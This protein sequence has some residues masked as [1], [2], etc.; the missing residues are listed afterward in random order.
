MGAKKMISLLLAL[1]LFGGTVGMLSACTP[2]AGEEVP[3]E[4]YGGLVV[5]PAEA[6]DGETPPITF[7]VQPLERKELAAY[8]VASAAIQGK[9][10]TANVTPRDAEDELDWSVAWASRV[11]EEW[12]SKTVTDYITVE[13]DPDDSHV[14]TVYCMQPFA[15]PIEVTAMIHNRPK[16]SA[17]CTAHFQQRYLNMTATISY[18]SRNRLE[19]GF[20]WEL[21]SEQNVSLAFPGYTKTFD[22]FKQYYGTGQQTG[23]FTVKITV[24]YKDEPYTIR[25]YVGEGDYYATV[26]VTSTSDYQAA[27]TASGGALTSGAMYRTI[28]TGSDWNDNAITLTNFNL[29]KMFMCQDGT[30]TTLDWTTFS[31]TLKANKDKVM[32]YLRANATVNDKER[33]QMWA[34][35]FSDGFIEAQPTDIEV[36]PDVVF[37]R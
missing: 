4:A 7:D 18:T 13:P 27:L 20:T 11:N 15:A 24:H 35:R 9:R 3:K 32:F 26:E 25:G 2:L 6:P 19:A 23:T 34:I 21:G 17:T 29:Q 10:V 31:D 33:S 28:A 5:T 1:S 16:I 36:G 12:K 30:D 14:A 37:T 22:E 8:S